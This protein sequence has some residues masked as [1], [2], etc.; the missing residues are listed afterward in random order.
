ME[1]TAAN[2][3]REAEVAKWLTQHNLDFLFGDS[4]GQYQGKASPFQAAI[5]ALVKQPEQK[6]SQS[7]PE[8]ADFLIDFEAYRVE[9]AQTLN[10]INNIFVGRAQKEGQKTVT[11]LRLDAVQND[12]NGGKRQ[13]SVQIDLEKL[14]GYIPIEENNF[15]NID[16][17]QVIEGVRQYL[18][19]HKLRLGNWIYSHLT[20]KL[21]DHNNVITREGPVEFKPFST[22]RYVVDKL[23]EEQQKTMENKVVSQ[24]ARYAK[25]MRI[26]K[27]GIQES[28]LEEMVR[29][30]LNKILF[31]GPDTG[32]PSLFAAIKHTSYFATTVEDILN[33]SRPTEL[34]IFK[35]LESPESQ[36]GKKHLRGSNKATVLRTQIIETLQQTM[37]NSI[38]LPYEQLEYGVKSHQSLATKILL[39]RLHDHIVEAYGN[40][41]LNPYLMLQGFS[42]LTD[43]DVENRRDLRD[44]HRMACIV[45]GDNSQVY[46][47]FFNWTGISQDKRGYTQIDGKDVADWRSLKPKLTKDGILINYS[48]RS[49]LKDY[50]HNPKPNGF[51]EI[52]MDVLYTKSER[53]IPF[54]V[55]M[56]SNNM[57]TYNRLSNDANH[58]LYKRKN[59]ALVAYC[60][61]H[62]S[63]LQKE[64]NATRFLLNQRLNL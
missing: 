23:G 27:S 36:K 64:V 63:I 40:G 48:K 62:G 24:M 56:M 20:E 34:D 38:H 4:T 49:D 5:N 25:K 11:C 15:V 61:Q 7:I 42:P 37:K 32:Y 44:L 45:Y 31:I 19:G 35:S 28:E 10:Y 59:E 8:V 14:V 1:K 57:D 6:W 51:A 50:I 53:P 16:R 46:D 13:A 22:I 47:M 58:K 39:F 3:D 12:G 26:A 17:P 41:L 52:K 2:A 9:G 30:D 21:D 60:V 54:E 55:Q 33:V 18:T 29:K 43:K